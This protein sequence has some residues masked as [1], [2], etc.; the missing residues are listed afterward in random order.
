MTP[1]WGWPDRSTAGKAAELGSSALHSGVSIRWP[2]RIFFDTDVPDILDFLHE[3]A[4]LLCQLLLR[5]PPMGRRPE[6]VRLNQQPTDRGG[7]PWRHGP[8]FL[9]EAAN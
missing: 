9:F 6:L 3:E 4:V 2:L 1:D 5:R 8:P 7:G